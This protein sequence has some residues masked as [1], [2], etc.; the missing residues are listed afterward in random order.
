M[1]FAITKMKEVLDPNPEGAQEDKG[2]LWIVLTDSQTTGYLGAVPVQAK[3]QL[4]YMTHEVLSFV[5]HLGGA[6][7]GFYGDNE[8]T[9]RQIL[10]TIITSHHAPRFGP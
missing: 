10:K 3:N 4:N 2:A 5:Q 8:P 7:A 1:D 6:E 9:I